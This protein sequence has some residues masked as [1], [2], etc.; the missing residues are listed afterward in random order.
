MV[1]RNLSNRKSGHTTDGSGRRDVWWGGGAGRGEA[2]RDA[3]GSLRPEDNRFL[4][5]QTIENNCFERISE[6]TNKRIPM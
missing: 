4:A 6:I 1:L 3:D 2:A 5:R